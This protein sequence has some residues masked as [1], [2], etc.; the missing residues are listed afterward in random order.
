MYASFLIIVLRFRAQRI[1]N[2]KRFHKKLQISALCE[3]Y[4][5][6]GLKNPS[7]Y[8]TSAISFRTRG[9]VYYHTA[10]LYFRTASKKPFL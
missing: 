2:P 10:L 3:K 9:K 6:V 8:D 1:S 4:Q 7:P 5:G